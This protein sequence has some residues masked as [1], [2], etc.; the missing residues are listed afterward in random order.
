[1]PDRRTKPDAKRGGGLLGIGLDANDGHKRVTTGDNFLL[2][3]GSEETHERMTDV[4]MR[5]NEKLKRQ[6][7]S[8][9]ELSKNEFEELAND[10][11]E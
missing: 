4:V 6:G 1:M 7:R 9:R 3:G 10:A 5:M 8:Y 2:V 11:L